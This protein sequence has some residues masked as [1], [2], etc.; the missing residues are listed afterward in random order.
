[1]QQ[2]VHL[3][4]QEIV[5]RGDRQRRFVSLDAATGPLQVEPL[6]GLAFHPVE[7]VV[8]LRHIRPRHDVERGHGYAPPF[9]EHF[10]TI[11]TGLLRATS[12]FDPCVSVVHRCLERRCYHRPRGVGL[13][14]R[15]RAW[16]KVMHEPYICAPGS[17]GSQAERT[18]RPLSTLNLIWVMPAEG[19]DSKLRQ[20]PGQGGFS[21]VVTGDRSGPQ[22]QEACGDET[23]NGRSIH[24]DYGASRGVWE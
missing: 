8:D 23:K 24:P 9:A 3:P 19:A 4:Q 16:L 2:I 17:L 12:D 6:L 5:V 14:T 11:C 21:V 7:R 1:M 20:P 10:S 22:A 18:A 13:L 15:P